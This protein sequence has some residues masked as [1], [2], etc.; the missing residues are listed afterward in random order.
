V[1]WTDPVSVHLTLRFL[2]EVAAERV[3]AVARAVGEAAAAGRPLS[4]EVTGPG[5]F[6]SPRR[7]RVLWL[8]VG[9]EVAALQALAADVEARLAALGVGPEEGAGPGPAAATPTRPFAPHLTV[10]RARSFR[11]APSIAPAL[12]SPAG[13]PLPW[14]ADALVLFES[15][16]RSG[17]ARHVALLRAPL[18]GAGR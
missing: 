18:G 8:G 10:G 16:L 6:P 11:G 3:A 2:G 12:A 7:P 14:R 9:G 4:L 15:H 5:A 13:P 17:G 1:R